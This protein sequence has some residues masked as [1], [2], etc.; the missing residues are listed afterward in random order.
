MFYQQADV[1][2]ALYDEAT[3]LLVSRSD[4]ALISVAVHHD[5]SLPRKTLNSHSEP[6]EAV[7]GGPVEK[8]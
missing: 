3:W 4:V 8:V 6:S 5:G 2:V 1:D 7:I